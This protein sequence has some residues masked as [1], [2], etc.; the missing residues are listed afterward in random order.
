MNTANK[1][2]G[3]EGRIVETEEICEELIAKFQI[4]FTVEDSTPATVERR[5]EGVTVEN[6]KI[7][8]YDI[9]RTSKHLD[10]FRASGSDEI[11]WLSCQGVCRD[12]Q[13]CSD[14]CQTI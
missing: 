8:R 6:V 1:G 14:I 12:I 10:Q 11:S 13:M 3:F 2:K 5:E 7:R 4:V 9:S